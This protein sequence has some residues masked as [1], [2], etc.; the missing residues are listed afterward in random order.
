MPEG[1]FIRDD[2]KALLLVAATV[3]ARQVFQLPTGEAAV[4]DDDTSVASSTYT[5]QFRT[6]GKFTIEKT[7]SM[8]LLAGQEVYWD[9]SANK[10]HYK[11]VNDRD[12]YLGVAIE[13]A[14]SGALT[15]NVDLNKRPKFL[16]DCLRNGCLT[17]IVG[18]QG[19]NTMGVFDRGGSKKFILSA[20]NEAQK[21]DMLSVDGFAP[22]A[23]CIVEGIFRVVSDG[24]GTVVDVS[25]GVASATHATDASLIAERLFVHLDANVLDIRAESSDG[26][27]TVAI[28]DTTIDYT[29]G[30]AV[31]NRVHVLYD[32]RNLNDIQVYVN[33]ALALDATVFR[34]N[35]A[36]GPLFLLAHVEKTIST[37][38]YELD[39][40]A[41]RCWSAEQ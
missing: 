35:A 26:T 28:T 24:A 20:T 27:T 21:L 5:D 23:K 32:L 6:R 2:D 30:S 19:L 25:L 16:I 13:D 15:V 22:G 8:V 39:L 29:E 31:A 10:A 14:S 12:F 17:A 7:T 1:T 41:L 37:D 18:T 9:H 36:V 34:L 40:D 4:L 33:G 11:R 3:D 38:T